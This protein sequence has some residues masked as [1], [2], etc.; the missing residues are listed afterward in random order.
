MDKLLPSII[1]GML[2]CASGA[3]A[4]VTYGPIAATGGTIKNTIITGGDATGAI[5]TPLGGT[6]TTLGAAL[7]G[8]GIGVGG[9]SFGQQVTQAL[10][11]AA[12]GAGQAVGGLMT[13]NA[14]SRSPL[15]SGNVASMTI[16]LPD[17]QIPT[18]DVVIFNANPTASTITNRATVVID[19]ADQA[20][21]VGVLHV[22]DCTGTQ[23]VC[24]AQ[25]WALPFALGGTSTTLY[26][27]IVARN[28]FTPSNL[29]IGSPAWIVTLFTQQN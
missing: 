2:V 24:Q 22:S 18:L 8:A 23:T 19:P 11:N 21:V 26:A 4:Q 27:A 13:F 5:V 25:Q 28:S 15:Y 3:S 12:Y 17:A 29:P 6:P 16:A 14:S 1:A 9:P 20:K 7:A 10:S